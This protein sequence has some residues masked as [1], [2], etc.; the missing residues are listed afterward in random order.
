M[1]ITKTNLTIY[2]SHFL[3]C[4]GNRMWGFGMGM[5]LVRI[6]DDSIQL[7]A[8]YGLVSGLAI[9]FFGALVGDW[10]DNTPRLK[11]AQLSLV[12][13]DALMLG[14][15]AVVIAFLWKT[16]DIQAS[17]WLSPF[18]KALIIFLGVLSNLAS[19]ARVIAVE[20]D[21]IVE[22]CGKNTDH[23]A[24]M[25]AMMRR[26]DQ[27]SMI[28]APMATGQVM[29]Y[30]GLVYG[31]IFIGGWNVLSV[32]VE[33]Y[34]MWKVYNTVPAL[35]AKKNERRVANVELEKENTVSQR[36]PAN[37]NGHTP[38]PTE[39]NA[40]SANGKNIDG[41]LASVPRA[42]GGTQQQIHPAGSS[43]T[44]LSEDLG[45]EMHDKTYGNGEVN[46]RVVV[47]LSRSRLLYQF[48]TLYRGWRTYVSYSVA[49]PGLALAFLYMTVLGFDNITVAYAVTQG[50]TESVLGILMGSSAVF[51][52]L[53]TFAYPVIRRQTGLVRSGFIALSCQVSCL[54]LCVVSV[55]MPGSPFD[56]LYRKV[57]DLPDGCEG[58]TGNA[59]GLL[60]TE[61]SPAPT[62][63]LL[64]SSADIMADNISN[65][66][67]DCDVHAKWVPDSPLSVIFLMAGIFLARF[68]VW[69]ADLTITQLFLEKVVPT[70]RGIVN[71]VQSSLNQLMDLLKFA[72][73][74]VLPDTQTFGFIIIISFS[75]IFTAWLL[76]A[77]F[78][79]RENVPL[80]VCPS[81]RSAVLA[82]DARDSGTARRSDS[83]FNADLDAMNVLV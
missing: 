37:G 77:I 7:S 8:T 28:L 61:T 27:I 76:Y 62:A 51:G 82:P 56:P 16:D 74:V 25:T 63:N 31:A 75:F 70:Q 13:Q 55:W 46:S 47:K 15:A 64:N 9:F 32:F 78:V 54:T 19:Q 57:F 20:R 26:V 14:C 73:V 21:W 71:G 44:H 50:L 2:C 69:I 18:L 24:S 40:E 3:S 23:L 12:L 35:K 34:L 39:T 5:F 66:T 68:G 10:V 81:A 6:A 58:D 80:C 17:G 65:R 49:L 42:E 48:V 45:E 43:L 36:Q 30:I 33:F 53:G 29:G 22:I 79:R 4:W 11:A 72:L 52:I 41:S 1:W 38:T 60:V 59:S 67:A 83:H